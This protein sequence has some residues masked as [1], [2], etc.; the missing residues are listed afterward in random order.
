[1]GQLSAHDIE[2]ISDQIIQI[3]HG[4]LHILFGWL[5]GELLL[6]DP[7]RKSTMHFSTHS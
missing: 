2:M 1:M 4:T 3:S 6:K 5:Q 7:F